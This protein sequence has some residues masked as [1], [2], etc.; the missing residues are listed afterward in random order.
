MSRIA[1]SG[2]L[3]KKAYESIKK[4]IINGELKPGEQV[5]QDQLAQKIGVSR[6]PLRK[7]M[8][9]LEREY[10]LEITPQGIFVRE[11]S[12][13]FIISVWEVRAV[14]EGLAC[15]LAATRI[16]DPNIA[17]LRTLFQGAY[18]KFLNGDEEPYRLADIEFHKKLIDVAANPMLKRNFDCTHVLD[19][20]F[21]QGLLRSPKETYPEHMEI[22]DALQRH[23]ADAAEKL[24]LEHCRKTTPYIP[25]RINQKFQ[26]K[27][28]SSPAGVAF[29]RLL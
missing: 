23:D 8:S 7:A 29:L 12:I 11:F 5:T 1:A 28:T 3:E 2:H 16:D 21:G 9:D 22:L 20:A 18:E 4:M 17:Y 26:L 15:R 13:D 27:K 19:I 10:L 14:L 25:E 6:T 24:M